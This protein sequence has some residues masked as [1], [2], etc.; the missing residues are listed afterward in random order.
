MDKLL[1]RMI[2]EYENHPNG[3][4]YYEKQ[5]MIKEIKNPIWSKL[6]KQ[7]IGF[8]GVLFL[9]MSMGGLGYDSDTFLIYLLLKE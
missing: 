3:Y 7:I 4:T 5:S 1:Y 8:V 6:S 9:I 2:I